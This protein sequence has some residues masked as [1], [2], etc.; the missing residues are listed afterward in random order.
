MNYFKMIKNE[1][2]CILSESFIDSG[3]AFKS[4]VDGSPIEMSF[5]HGFIFRYLFPIASEF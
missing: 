5:K 4:K 3:V 1:R 2:G